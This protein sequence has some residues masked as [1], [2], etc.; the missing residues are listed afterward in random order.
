MK[1]NLRTGTY[2]QILYDYLSQGNSITTKD[3]MYHLGIGDLQGVIRDLIKEGVPI[4]KENIQV[5]T[6]RFRKDG[7]VK[8]AYV[9]KYS[10]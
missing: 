9:I 7:S 1:Y 4:Q 2:K 3:A 5:P 8:P 10:L 6:R